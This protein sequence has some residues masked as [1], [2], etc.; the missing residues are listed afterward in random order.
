[1]DEWWTYT[2]ADFL[3]FSPRTYYRMLEHHNVAVWPGQ[4]LTLGLGLGT[5]ALLRR[6]TPRQGRVISTI[7]AVLWAW[8]AWSFLW[9]RYTSINPAAVYLAWL[10]AVEAL[11]LV[12]IGVIR[13]RL[14]YH[15][16]R[17]GAGILGIALFTLALAFYPVLAPLAGRSWHHGEV[18]GVAPDP[19]VLGTIA[20][21]VLAEGRPRWELL[22]IPVLWCAI[23]GATLWAMGS[24]EALIPPLTALL[25]LAA[26]VRLQIRGDGNDYH[27]PRSGR[28][29][30]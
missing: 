12:W 9:Q 23:S 15:P 27:A 26:S 20:L 25:V 14:L 2:L 8:V 4:I 22:A 29:R 17:H 6:P 24:P 3:L 28:V 7:V 11:L 19:T 30:W 18:F 16:G 21:L 5:F 10:F 13:G 1:M